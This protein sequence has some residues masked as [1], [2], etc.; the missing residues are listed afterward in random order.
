MRPKGKQK[1][2]KRDPTY[3]ME[4]FADEICAWIAA[5]KTLRD[6]CRQDGKPSWDTVY[7][8]A[9]ADEQF[10]QRF[11]RAREDGQ[12]VL[13]EECM[14]I[15]DTQPADQTE[16]QWQRLRIDTRLKLLAKWN[17]RK[18]GDRSTVDHAG[19]VSINVITGVPKRETN[20]QP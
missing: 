6:Y 13:S 19:G 7:V 17:P 2:K 3:R 14:E 12:D 11:A 18:Y 1:Y 4:D 5:G 20:D 8:W 16:V 9:K 10:A 15:A